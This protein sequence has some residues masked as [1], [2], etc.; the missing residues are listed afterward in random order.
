[1]RVE[2]GDDAD[3]VRQID[4]VLERRAALVVDEQE[5]QTRRWM[6]SRKRRDA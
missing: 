1:M 5:R 3:R 2:V 4:A 6:R